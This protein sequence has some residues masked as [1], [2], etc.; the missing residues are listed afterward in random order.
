VVVEYDADQ[1]RYVAALA[2]GIL[3]VLRVNPVYERMAKDGAV[4]A[5]TREF[6]G[7]NVK[8]AEW[9][10]EALHHRRT[11]LMR[12]VEEVIARQRPWFD[13]GPEAL[14]RL[15]MSEVAQS[16]GLSTGTVSRAVSGKWMQTPRGIV[17]LR[18]FFTGGVETADGEGASWEAV[19]QMVKDVIDG[20]DRAHPLSDEAIAGRLK[21]RGVTIARRTVVKYREQLGIP[22]ARHRKS[23]GT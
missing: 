18:K 13:E 7:T 19:R 11:T 12:V 20:E 5:T 1:D 6:V 10:I 2:D 21:D 3:P 4:D 8:A 15:E 23:H 22:S 9:L 16:L 17:E 14:R